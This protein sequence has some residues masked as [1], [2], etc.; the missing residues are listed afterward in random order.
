MR[1]ENIT[2]TI[3]I[4]EDIKEGYGIT[5]KEEISGILF[6]NLKWSAPRDVLM[7]KKKRML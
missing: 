6:E 3:E 7:F 4:F 2:G 5:V 1:R